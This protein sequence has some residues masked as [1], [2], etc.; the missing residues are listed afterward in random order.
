M[1]HDQSHQCNN[2]LRQTQSLMLCMRMH[3]MLGSVRHVV[4]RVNRVLEHVVSQ[5]GIDLL[6]AYQCAALLRQETV[7]SWRAQSV[8]RH[9]QWPVQLQ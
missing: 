5:S 3:M 1:I 9:R 4:E 6:S 2:K 8:M 7:A